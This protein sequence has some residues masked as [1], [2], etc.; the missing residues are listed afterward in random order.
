MAARRRYDGFFHGFLKDGILL[1]VV[2]IKITR[3][4]NILL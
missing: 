1:P 4:Y 2:E 3:L